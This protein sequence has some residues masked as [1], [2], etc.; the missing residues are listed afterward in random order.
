[1][2]YQSVGLTVGPVLLFGSKEVTVAML[3]NTS[4]ASVQLVLR[5]TS[6]PNESL[7]SEY[8]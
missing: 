2:V 6:V 5:L 3:N 1:M 8:W 7:Q 4:L